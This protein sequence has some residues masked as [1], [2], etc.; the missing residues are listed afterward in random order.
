ASL[1]DVSR[2]CRPHALRENLVYGLSLS[3]GDV[4]IEPGGS[5]ARA[6]IAAV[7]NGTRGLVVVVIHSLDPPAVRRFEWEESLSSPAELEDALEQA[8]HF[9]R[10]FGFSMDPCE[11]RDLGPEDRERRL[12]TWNQIRKARA[13]G[14]SPGPEVPQAAVPG[15]QVGRPANLDDEDPAEAQTASFPMG[16][17]MQME[18]EHGRESPEVPETPDRAILG[19][20]KLKQHRLPDA[21]ARVLSHF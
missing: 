14:G 6:G 15:S 10:S 5:R 17:P 8:E 3:R 16:F 19:R 18:L 21:R 9:A 7:W 11:F 4:E 13:R 1:G 2:S 12:G 20:M